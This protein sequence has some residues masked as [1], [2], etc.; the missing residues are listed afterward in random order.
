MEFEHF[1]GYDD[2]GGG[3]RFFGRGAFELPFLEAFFEEVAETAT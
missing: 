3:L 2:G 1:F